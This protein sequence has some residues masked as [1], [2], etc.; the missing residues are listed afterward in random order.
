MWRGGAPWARVLRG[1]EVASAVS[2]DSEATGRKVTF[3]ES[4]CRRPVNESWAARP[5]PSS[6]RL[7]PRWLPASV[8]VGLPC[9]PRE[10]VQGAVPRVGPSLASPRS[11]AGLWS[12]RTGLSEQGPGPRKGAVSPR[13]GAAPHARLQGVW[14]CAACDTPS[15]CA[16][17]GFD[18]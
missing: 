15:L 6:W 1:A 4:R 11:A 18:V 7:E 10:V 16:E 8:R 12:P 5:L 14:L 13:A 9:G 3:R 17:S 2:D